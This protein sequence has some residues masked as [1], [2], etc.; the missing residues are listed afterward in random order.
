MREQLDTCEEQQ[1]QVRP[2]AR[3]SARVISQDEIEKFGFIEGMKVGYLTTCA[4][5]PEVG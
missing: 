4:P 5:E 2:F 3:L 1:D